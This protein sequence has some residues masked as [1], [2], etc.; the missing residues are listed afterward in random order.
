MSKEDIKINQKQEK[1]H[2]ISV[3]CQDS[4]LAFFSQG[5]LFPVWIECF[6]GHTDE[7]LRDIW[8]RRLFTSYLEYLSKQLSGY[9]KSRLRISQP[10]VW[11][12]M[13]TCLFRCSSFSLEKKKIIFFLLTCAIDANLPFWHAEIL[14]WLTAVEESHREIMWYRKWLFISQARGCIYLTKFLQ[15]QLKV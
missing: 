9:F 10:G 14:K 5:F 3:K 13:H 7:N 4:F 6:I 15:D 12:I 1:R 11:V 2:L 8:A